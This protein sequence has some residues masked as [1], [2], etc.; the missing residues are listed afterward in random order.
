MVIATRNELLSF[1]W[2]L[3]A[4][5]ISRVSRVSRVSSGRHAWQTRLLGKQGF[6]EFLK[7]LVFLQ[8]LV[9]GILGKHVS[10]ANKGFP[11]LSSLKSL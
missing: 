1:S 11:S 3:N 8:F 9:A 6:L 5:R 7:F 10:L 4:C 2:P